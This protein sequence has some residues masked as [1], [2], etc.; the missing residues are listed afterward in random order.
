[1]N[2]KSINPLLLIGLIGFFTIGSSFVVDLYRAFGGEKDIYWT[3]Q[4]MKLPLQETQNDFQ[5]YIADKLLQD[6]L[7]EKTLF[8][9]DGDGTQFDL[10]E[11]DIAVRV[12]NWHRVKSAVLTKAV[13]T[14]FAFG[15]SFTLLITGWVQT[16]MQKKRTG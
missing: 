10:V 6:H 11:Q 4:Q 3:H 5:L 1:M 14:G 16:C 2:T 13:F 7:S 8:A 15:A 9:L 12:N